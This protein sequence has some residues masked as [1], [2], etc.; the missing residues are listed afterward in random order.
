MRINATPTRDAAQ[1]ASKVKAQ[2]FT[3][4]LYRHWNQ[5][6]GEKRSHL[7]LVSVGSRVAS[8]T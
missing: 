3:H 2:L 5:Y 8:A 6:T 1:A 4:L 7:F